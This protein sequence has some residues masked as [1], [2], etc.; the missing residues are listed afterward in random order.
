MKKIL[1]NNSVKIS[2]ILALL[3]ITISTKTAAQLIGIKTICDSGCHYSSIASAV[4]AL[5]NVGVG[6]GGVIFKISPGHIDTLNSPIIL[7]TSG[8]LSK[9]ISFI[10]SDTGANPKLVAYSGS[11]A[12]DGMFILSGINYI[13]IDG[14]DLEERSNNKTNTTQ[15]EWGFALLK[16]VVSSAMLGC[17]NNTIKNCNIKLNK[18]NSSVSG[19]EM[20]NLGSIGIY[21]ANQVIG[22]SKIY[23]V[24]TFTSS[25]NR[26][27]F[28]S[29]FL[30]D[31]NMGIYL[32]GN[33]GSVATYDQGNIIGLLNQ[34]N[35]ITNFGGNDGGVNIAATCQNNLIIEGNY[36]FGNDAA[37][38][39]GQIATSDGLNSSVRINYNTISLKDI[40]TTPLISNWIGDN[41]T[42]NK[43]EIIGN[44]IKNC[45]FTNRTTNIDM[46]GISNSS[47]AYSVKIERNKFID[48]TFGS[49]SKSY[50]GRISIIS[51]GGLNRKP[52]S[53]VSISHNLIKNNVC[54]NLDG[55]DIYDIRIGWGGQINTISFDTIQNQVYHGK[56]HQISFATYMPNVYNVNNNI[57]TDNKIE[58]GDEGA[59]SGIYFD[60]DYYTISKCFNNTIGNF[61]VPKTFTGWVY[62]IAS[63]R[64]TKY[65]Y[66]Y[67]N[68]IYDYNAGG[69][70]LTGILK[71]NGNAY[72]SN[73]IIG[74]LST[75]YSIYNMSIR[76]IDLSE[77]DELTTN[78]VVSNNTVYINKTSSTGASFSSAA[79]LTNTYQSVV[80]YNNNIFINNAIPGSSGKSIAHYH[81]G[82]N[83]DFI[84]PFSQNNI[85]YAGTPSAKNLIYFDG[86]HSSQTMDD[87]RYYV[88][89]CDMGSVSENVKFVSTTGSS[90]YF[91]HIDSSAQTNVE[92]NGRKISDIGIDI[93]KEIRFGFNGYKGSGT[94]T[95]I[96]ADEGE[97][98][99]TSSD[100]FP[101]AI[102][103]FIN[104][105]Q[106]CSDSI[107]TYSVTLSDKSGIPTT[108]KN[109]PR[110]Y[111]KKNTTG[112]FQSVA[113]SLIKGNGYNGTWSFSVNP[114]T[115]GTLKG[116]DVI[117]MFVIV[118]DNSSTPNISSFPGGA[119]ASNVNSVSNPPKDTLWNLGQAGTMSGTYTVGYSGANYKTINAAIKDILSHGI[120]TPIIINIMPGVYR[121]KI[122]IGAFE[123]SS[124]TKMVTFQS[125]TGKAEDVIII[126]S[127]VTA[128]N[129]WVWR[130]YNSRYITIRRLTFLSKGTYGCPLLVDGKNTKKINI[131]GCNFIISDSNSTSNRFNPMIVNP[132]QGLYDYKIKIDSLIIDSN[133]F[134]YGYNGVTLHGDSDVSRID[135]IYFRNNTIYGAYNSALM[136]KNLSGSKFQN[137]LI[138]SR[139]NGTQ[140]NYGI[141]M[142]SV[143]QF[144]LSGS[145]E[146]S[147]NRINGTKTGVYMVHCDNGPDVNG[148]FANNIIVAT[149]TFGIYSYDCDMWDFYHNS[150]NMY[151]T[152]KKMPHYPIYHRNT[153]GNRYKN[154]IFSVSS[155]GAKPESLSLYTDS[156][157]APGDIDNNIYWNPNGKFLMQNLVAYDTTKF[158]NA[159]TGG[160]GSK[161]F[162]PL[163]DSATDLRIKFSTKGCGPYLQD[164]PNDCFGTNR[165]SKL[166]SIGAHEPLPL[167]NDVALLNIVS[168]SLSISTNQQT[169]KLLIQNLGKNPL[170]SIRASYQVNGGSIIND[171]FSFAPIG[172][173]DSSLLTFKIPFTHNSGC[174]S[175]RSW[176]AYP[177]GFQDLNTLNDSINN[178]NIVIQ[179]FASDITICRGNTASLT[180]KGI[181]KLSWYSEKNGGTYLGKG[182]N[183][184]TPKLSITT[185][186]YVQDST[187][188][189]T[190]TPVTVIINPFKIIADATDTS[191]CP[192]STVTLSGWGAKSYKWSDGVKDGIAFVPKSAKT[193]MLIGT[194]TFNCYDTALIKIKLDTIPKI[195]IIAKDTIV[196]A[197]TA[198]K[199]FGNGAISYSWSHGIING[200]NFIPASTA[201]F[202]VKGTDGN[203]CSDT[204]SI[205]IIV[206]PLPNVTI[207]ASAAFIC[208]RDSVKLI[209]EGANNYKWLSP[210]KNGIWFIPSAT[211]IYTVIGT[212]TNLCEDTAKI[213]ITVNPLPI[214]T[215]QSTKTSICDGTSI[216]LTGSGSAFLYYWSN[217]V[218]N[219]VAFI[220]KSSGIYTVTGKNS[221]NCSDTSSIF[222]KVNP[223]PDTAVNLNGS[224]ITSKQNGATYKWFNCVTGL[225]S[226]AINQSYSAKKTG[227]YAVIVTLNGC[228]DTSDCVKISTI[229]INKTIHN[230]NNLNIYP[231]PNNGTFTIQS[232]YEGYYSI[233]NELG[234]SIQSFEL[235]SSNKYTITLEKMSNGIYFVIGYS[236]KYRSHLS[237]QKVVII[238]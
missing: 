147:G 234:Q 92:S 36:I 2:F 213:T 123:G 127:S 80:S 129:N 43:V 28:L 206:N 156:R 150:I 44:I 190:R 192:G 76:G 235:N 224:T 215:A 198:I 139:A 19:T 151:N 231:N 120:C 98:K 113:G 40:K 15:M 163:F 64:G 100:Q 72:I 101:P 23:A 193:Y 114:K 220:P 145:S 203:N 69:G 135:D 191:I 34:G 60:G 32:R 91:L 5:N 202:K 57:L 112:S 58:Y 41:G 51:S 137:N 164:V 181:G 52:G 31:I 167:S 221:Y 4:N 183:Y 228:T 186:F 55:A 149:D 121:E 25:S 90:P 125:S 94:S 71:R 89:T 182:A 189:S 46:S 124:A 238:R 87:Y 61:T 166:T 207:K 54:L 59:N 117:Y 208:K 39:S 128:K 62:G 24:D 93:D 18:L 237:C 88:K 37:K 21:L 7:T 86:S 110:L 169:V 184:S 95:D 118:Q 111:Y 142:E 177:N 196:C 33:T 173:F 133:T 104:P 214:V 42:N 195:T 210:V 8:T 232:N 22:S 217:G 79:F 30:S 107:F 157:I 175:L 77:N 99:T 226:G 134:K 84:S 70:I 35:K 171:T 97:F 116:S 73:N 178:L 179:A 222:I 109:L 204:A 56:N 81:N 75:P 194:D 6:K 50:T 212:D 3:F 153:V 165:N 218:K 119:T 229:G 236:T 227:Y 20:Y 108:G 230:D 1:V 38:G 12:H 63:A 211:S 162:K 126:D 26:N 96:G 85:F 9:P 65:D 102:F 174:L 17:S 216:I 200:F 180:A 233:T 161:N 29:N 188:N 27:R 131:I 205:K 78:T 115:L 199:L 140:T 14:I 185:T 176:T 172:T 146:I 49:S 154:N 68:K 223:L 130:F 144:M 141:F 67:S 209:A 105:N 74:N 136:L 152:T 168:P 47:N 170:S 155:S 48:N 122:S 11:G 197:G 66:I 201:R 53:S 132:T 10:K 143:G 187:C 138:N 16:R 219:G 82:T 13:T 103:D 45:E 159:Y 106:S 83:F 160:A 158:N 225:I 148:L